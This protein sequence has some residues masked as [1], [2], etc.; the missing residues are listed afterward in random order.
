VDAKNF[1]ICLNC[2]D[3]RVQ[4]PVIHWI[5]AKYKVDYVDMIT[6]AGMD[7]VLADEN[8]DIEK[9]LGTIDLLLDRN[10]TNSVFIVGHYD[11]LGNSV[12]EKTHKELICAA[13]ERLKSS[14]SICRVIGLW[15]SKESVVEKIVEK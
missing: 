12:D 1:V 4:L 6:N 9:V 5:K 14:K 2:V 11:C 15:V 7:R 13:A 3:G 10:E 8:A